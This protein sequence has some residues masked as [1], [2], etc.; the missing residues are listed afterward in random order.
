MCFSL[1]IGILFL[2]ET[3]EDK[4]NRKD[5]GAVAGRWI[6][7]KLRGHEDD[8]MVLA[9]KAG[10]IEQTCYLLADESDDEQPPGY[11]STEGSPR[12]TSATA[13]AIRT[14]PRTVS[15]KTSR[16]GVNPQIVLNIVGL[17]VL[18]L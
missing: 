14:P 15:F 17:G 12:L 16:F 4:K 2:E 18:A 7:R 5:Y 11:Q 3:H 6:L 9:A 8:D 13:Q 1:I 10:Y